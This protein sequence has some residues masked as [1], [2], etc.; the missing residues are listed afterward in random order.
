MNFRLKLFVEEVETKEYNGH[1]YMELR[2]KKDK[3]DK[4]YVTITS[5]VL[6]IKEGHT[7]EF[8]LQ[9]RFNKFKKRNDLKIVNV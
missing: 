7:Y 6:D 3:S 1:K 2:V 5:K 9:Y 8:E 4:Y